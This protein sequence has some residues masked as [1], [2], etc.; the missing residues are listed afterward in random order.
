MC[1]TDHFCITTVLHYK[2]G[3]L[4]TVI[5]FRLVQIL[6]TLFRRFMITELL[7]Y[8]SISQRQPNITTLTLTHTHTYTVAAVGLLLCTDTDLTG[9]RKCSHQTL[10]LC[11]AQCFFINQN[12]PDKQ[13]DFSSSIFNSSCYPS[14]IRYNVSPHFRR[15]C[16]F[17]ITLT[18]RRGRYIFHTAGLTFMVKVEGKWRENTNSVH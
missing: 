16:F 5:I 10:H 7:M 13:H 2:W 18:G 1:G 15:R 9:Q 6:I 8:S 11:M 14:L 3:H 12:W 17:V 4:Y